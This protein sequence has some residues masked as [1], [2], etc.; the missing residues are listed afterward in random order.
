VTYFNPA[1]YPEIIRGLPEIDVPIEGVRGW[2][3]QSDD[4]QVVFFDIDPVGNIP[5]HSHGAQYGVVISGE[6]DLTIEGE[7]KT[8]KGGDSYFIPKGAIHSA[9]FR[10]RT[11]VID[12]FE[13]R[14]R[15]SVK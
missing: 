3:I 4:H 9:V 5:E 15:Y 8:C 6:M 11:I 14:D 7:T 10:E 13:D 12:F 2:L 1:G